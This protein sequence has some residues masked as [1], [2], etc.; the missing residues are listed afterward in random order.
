METAKHINRLD[1]FMDLYNL[2]L[3]DDPDV[4]T[5]LA[6]FDPTDGA[7]YRIMKFQRTEHTYSIMLADLDSGDIVYHSSSFDDRKKKYQSWQDNV[8]AVLNSYCLIRNQD[9]TLMDRLKIDYSQTP[10]Q[11]ETYVQK[12]LAFNKLIQ[13]SDFDPERK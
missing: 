2:R 13:I 10:I 11:T 9:M 12:A 1:T 6:F 7:H 8:E 3:A 5:R 4:V